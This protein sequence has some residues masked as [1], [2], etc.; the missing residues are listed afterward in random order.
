VKQRL[1][2]PSYLYYDFRYPVFRNAFTVR[3]LIIAIIGYAILKAWY[4]WRRR[5][6][7]PGAAPPSERLMLTRESS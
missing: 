1:G 3:Y 5:L 2:F 7:H 6:V 4:G